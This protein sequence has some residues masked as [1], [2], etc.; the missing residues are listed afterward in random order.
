MQEVVG[1]EAEYNEETGAT[2]VLYC[3][4]RTNAQGWMVACDGGCEV[5]EGETASNTVCSF[6]TSAKRT[7]DLNRGQY[8]T[9]E[10]SMQ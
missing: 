5:Q 4:C 10:R 7:Q 9:L 2:D 8:S 6:T 3:I 1:E